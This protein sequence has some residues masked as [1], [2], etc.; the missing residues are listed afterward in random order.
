[1]PK[2]NGVAFSAGPCYIKNTKEQCTLF[3]FAGMHGAVSALRESDEI[4]ELTQ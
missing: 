2:I 4:S 3:A 1:M